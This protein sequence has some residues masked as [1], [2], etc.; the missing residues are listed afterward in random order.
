MSSRIVF[1]ED[2]RQVFCGVATGTRTLAEDLSSFWAE[3]AHRAVTI[4]WVSH[5]EDGF[6]RYIDYRGDGPANRLRMSRISSGSH[7]TPVRWD[8]TYGAHCFLDIVEV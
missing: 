8:A 3:H 7:C 5:D 4:E 6:A 1:N 2:G